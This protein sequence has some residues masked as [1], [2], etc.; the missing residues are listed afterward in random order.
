MENFYTDF[1]LAYSI[2]EKGVEDSWLHVGRVVLTQATKNRKASKREIESVRNHCRWLTENT[3]GEWGLWLWGTAGSFDE[4]VAAR[5]ALYE[6][7]EKHY[8]DAL[9]GINKPGPSFR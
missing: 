7:G 2:P 3:Y 8:R 5:P 4:N 1:V 9:S 6:A